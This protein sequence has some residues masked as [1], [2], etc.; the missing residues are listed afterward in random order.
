[1]PSLL[2]PLLSQSLNLPSTSLL[3]NQFLDQPIRSHVVLLLPSPSPKPFQ[4]LANLLLNASHL[5]PILLSSLLTQTL[6]RRK[7]SLDPLRPLP[8]L[9]TCVHLLYKTTTLLHHLAPSLQNRFLQQQP[10][11]NRPT[12]NQN[13]NLQV[14]P[15]LM[16]LRT[17]LLRSL[18]PN[19]P[20]PPRHLGNLP[21]HLRPEPA[22][23]RPQPKKSR[24]LHLAN[25]L[26]LLPPRHLNL[27][28][29]LR[30]PLLLL[31]PS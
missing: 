16:Q 31:V 24:Q 14:P 26:P 20:L 8:I 13:R 4:I 28:L 11:Q 9:L 30:L 22:L 12:Q 3:K 19:P 27:D 1:M 7:G 21:L 23:F 2:V 6:E 17:R 25:P 15:F 5:F 10:R 18:Y 29:P